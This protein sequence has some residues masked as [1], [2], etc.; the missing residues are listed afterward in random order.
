MTSYEYAVRDDLDSNNSDDEAERIQQETISNVE[1]LEHGD[2]ETYAHRFFEN[3]KEFLAL[4]GSHLLDRCTFPAFFDYCQMEREKHRSKTG[5]PP[6]S[7][8][9]SN[10]A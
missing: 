9:S 2:L 5:T 7:P 3:I 10:D 6:P 1:E 8:D 4:R